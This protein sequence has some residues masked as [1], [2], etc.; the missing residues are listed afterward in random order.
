[1]EPEAAGVPAAKFLRLFDYL[2]EQ[3][4][5]ST[6]VAAAIGLDRVAITAAPASDGLPRLHYARLYNETVRRL[7]SSEPGLPWGAGIGGKPFRLMAFCIVSCRTL[8]EALAR[9]A[10]FESVVSPQLKGDRITQISKLAP[11]KKIRLAILG[12]TFERAVL[13][14]D[15]NKA[16]CLSAIK[17]PK[18]KENEVV[19]YCANRSLA[20]DVI[21]YIAGRREWTK[22][23]AVKLNLVLNPKTPLTESTKLLMLLRDK[24]VRQV[25]KSRGVPSAV[26]A[27]A[28]KIIAQ[29]TGGK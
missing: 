7:Q 17:S 26:V 9:A 2:D 1:M 19:T 20:H 28:R 5:D 6:T 11:M 12:N 21:R 29:R 25:A 8:G 18:V 23:Y 3:G 14:R 16:V 27:Q 24:D 15:S 13:I 10:D 22:L 4:I